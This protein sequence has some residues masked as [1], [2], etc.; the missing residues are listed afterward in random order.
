[1]STYTSDGKSAGMGSGI[2]GLL[3]AGLV[4]AALSF[5]AVSLAFAAGDSSGD[6]STTNSATA[7]KCKD[8]QVWDPEA[9]GFFTKGKCV[10]AADLKKDDTKTTPEKQGLIYDQGKAL[11]KA[12]NYEAA[13]GML[14]LAPDQNDPRVQNYLGYSNRKLGRMDEALGHYQ[15]AI[16]LDPDFSL[17]REYLGE[18]YIQLGQLEKAR[19]QL[20][21]IER[22]CGNRSCGE[23]GDLASLIV[24]SQASQ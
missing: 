23:Y 15:L 13:I 1:M 6:S 3:A 12:G 20:S 7:M 2:N 11:A 18:A 5:G 14:A 9:K 21:E 8:G 17:V 10:E 22:I 24:Q 4:A 19:E 16:S